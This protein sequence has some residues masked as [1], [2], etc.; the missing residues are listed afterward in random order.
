ML[1]AV[2]LALFLAMVIAGVIRSQLQMATQ[3]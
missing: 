1:N 2:T 3:T